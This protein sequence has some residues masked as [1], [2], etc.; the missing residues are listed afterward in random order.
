[1]E[2]N[3]NSFFPRII[4]TCALY[5]YEEQKRRREDD[6]DGVHC[7]C[8]FSTWWPS[9]SCSWTIECAA[10]AVLASTDWLRYGSLCFGCSAFALCVRYTGNGKRET[11]RRI[12]FDRMHHRSSSL[13]RYDFGW[14]S[15]QKYIKSKTK[16]TW[17]MAYA[18]ESK[19][20][21]IRMENDQ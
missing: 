7:V 15:K 11:K 19:A 9:C 2:W 18:V 5:P 21:P 17:L 14:N 3:R 1:M 20:D 16:Q 4:C 6:D 12:S 8:L 10:I 13:R